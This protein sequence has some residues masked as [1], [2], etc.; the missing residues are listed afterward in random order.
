M[1]KQQWNGY[2]RNLVLTFFA[3]AQYSP[4]YKGFFFN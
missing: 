4:I 3:N 1:H 2:P